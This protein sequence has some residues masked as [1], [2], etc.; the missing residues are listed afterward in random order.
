MGDFARLMNMLK[1]G[2]ND[3]IKTFHEKRLTKGTHELMQ[4]YEITAEHLVKEELY[5][6]L[7]K[8]G[9]DVLCMRDV[10]PVF[11]M[12]KNELRFVLPNA[13]TDLLPAVAPGAQ[14]MEGSNISFATDVTFVADKYGEK[15]GIPEELIDDSEFDVIELIMYQEG[16]RAENRV[17]DLA[18]KA[19]LD[20]GF[21]ATSAD[22]KGVINTIMDMVTALRNNNYEPDTVVLSPNAVGA[23][24]EYIGGSS[25]LGTNEVGAYEKSG[26]PEAFR[27]KDIGRPLV[28]LKP[29]TLSLGVQGTT[30]GSFGVTATSGTRY[31][32]CVL[33]RRAAGGIGMR[34]DVKVDDFED[35]LNDLLNVKVTMRMDAK[36][37]WAN[38]I[39]FST[40]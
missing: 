22:S 37:F 24:L 27:S 1:A 30:T 7:M 34:D 38:G 21:S 19:L 18:M 29:H 23:V 28:G 12:S 14:L 6:V 17:N 13:N 32:I 39:T 40:I 35:P 25:D 8:G 5:K 4:A 3:D 33:D 16:K 20:S 9:E 36:K 31:D 11:T 2:K 26:V 10:L 15:V